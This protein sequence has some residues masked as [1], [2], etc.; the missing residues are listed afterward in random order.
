MIEK[1]LVLIKPDG[2]ERKLITDVAV[3]LEAEGLHMKEMRV[4]ELSKEQ[5]EDLYNEHKG[6]WFFD[7]NIQHVTSGPVIA[8][9][10]EG[11]AAVSRARKLVEHIREEHKDWVELP[12]NLVHATDSP[13]KASHELNAV[14]FD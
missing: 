11:E 3:A 4:L 7:R 6:K 12:K 8:F 5:A 14:G 10:I 13:E 2:V 1:T 9:R